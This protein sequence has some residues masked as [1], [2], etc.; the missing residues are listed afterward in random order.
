MLSKINDVPKCLSYMHTLEPQ[1]IVQH[2]SKMMCTEHKTSDPFAY[3]K[4]GKLSQMNNV[5]C[6]LGA[7]ICEAV[8][9]VTPVE[10]LGDVKK[11]PHG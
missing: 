2:A 4:S 9:A 11:S 6:G 10:P 3:W 5:I 7:G 8:C 1:G